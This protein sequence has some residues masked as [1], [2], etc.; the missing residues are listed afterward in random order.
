MI[1]RGALR[2]GGQAGLALLE[3][4][5]ALEQERLSVGLIPLAHQSDGARP[6]FH[7]AGSSFTMPV[8]PSD[9]A[10]IS[11]DLRSL[12]NNVVSAPCFNSSF[13]M[14]LW[15]SHPAAIKGVQP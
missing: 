14:L 2:Y 12:F 5:A 1:R 11:A 3:S 10:N 4:L 15:P 7:L 6:A 13:T 9:S 8:W